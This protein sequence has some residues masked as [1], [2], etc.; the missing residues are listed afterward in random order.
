MLGEKSGTL[1]GELAS[2]YMAVAEWELRDVGVES[3]ASQASGGDWTLAQS[4]LEKIAESHTPLR[5]RAEEML[6]GLR[7]YEATHERR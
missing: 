6:R 7:V 5:D 2:N 1:V 4:Y 3:A